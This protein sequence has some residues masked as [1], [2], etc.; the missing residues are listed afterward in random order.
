MLKSLGS[1][2]SVL[3]SLCSSK[4]KKNTVCEEDN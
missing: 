1:D 3:S 4:R 2:Q